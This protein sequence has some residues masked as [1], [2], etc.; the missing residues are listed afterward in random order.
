VDSIKYPLQSKPE[1]TFVGT[2]K[3]AFVVVVTDAISEKREWQ[4]TS[5]R[6]PQQ[7]PITW[8]RWRNLSTFSY[9]LFIPIWLIALAL[10]ALSAAPWIKPRF[11]LR[12]LLIA[13]TLLA[14]VL[15]LVIWAARR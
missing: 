2:M 7:F 8:L 3:G 9:R 6:V 10:S 15:G 14:V 13:T 5:R 4:Y 12:T 1:L 11:T